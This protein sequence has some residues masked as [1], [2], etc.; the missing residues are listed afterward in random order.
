VGTMPCTEDPGGL[1]DWCAASQ[2]RIAAGSKQEAAAAGTAPRLA[3]LALSASIKSM[4][5]VRGGSA[6]AMV[7][8]SPAIFASM[9]ACSFFR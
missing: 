4:T 5:W 6:G 9:T 8:G 2:S 1:P 7:T 3:R